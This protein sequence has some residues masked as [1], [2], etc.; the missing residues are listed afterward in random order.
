MTSFIGRNGR[1]RLVLREPDE[2]HLK[3]LG[4]LLIRL[5]FVF[6]LMKFLFGLRTVCFLV[7][8]LLKY[9]PKSTPDSTYFSMFNCLNS[10]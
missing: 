4:R 8:T 3:L 5:L 6:G 1:R 2:G 10:K 7:Q 9:L